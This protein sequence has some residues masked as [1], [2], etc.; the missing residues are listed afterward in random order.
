MDKERKFFDDKKNALKKLKKAINKDIADEKIL[1]ILD[2]INQSEKFYTSSSCAGR[3]ALLELPSIG[4][5]KNA[6]FL[7]KWHRNIKPSEMISVSKNAKIGQLWLLAQSP[8]IHITAKT[9]LDAEHMLKTVI[10]SG[11]KNSG[12]KSL[13]RK[14]VIEVCS[15]E[16]L[17]APVGKDGKLFCNEEYLHLLVEIANDVIYRSELK[18]DRLKNG[19]KKKI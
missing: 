10:S 9:N 3:I 15:T 19:L 5:K 16:R 18:L 12:L 17:D 7:G 11:F 1:P 14:I 8:I 13:G 2:I 6:R 4:D